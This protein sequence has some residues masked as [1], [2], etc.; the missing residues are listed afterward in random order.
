M[1]VS[2]KLKRIFMLARVMS[3]S[4]ST[5]RVVSSNKLFGQPEGSFGYKVIKAITTAFFILVMVSYS[6]VFGFAYMGAT[7]D[8]RSFSQLVIL[9]LIVIVLLFG[10]YNVGI[11]MFYSQN[12]PSYLTMPITSTELI[13]ARILGF[14]KNTL[15]I[16]L[17]LIPAYFVASLMYGNGILWSLALCVMVLLSVVPI[18]M[19]A[20]LITFFLIRFTPLGNSENIFKGVYGVVSTV[21]SIAMVYVIYSVV[22]SDQGLSS[23]VNVIPEGALEYF[24]AFV[25]PG[26]FLIPQISELATSNLGL[27]L[28]YSLIFLVLCAIYLAIAVLVMRKSYLGIVNTVIAGGKLDDKKAE[29]IKEESSHFNLDD[30]LKDRSQLASFISL[31]FNRFRR[32]PTLFQQFALA[33]I[34]MPIFIMFVFYFSSKKLFNEELGISDYTQM[35]QAL[36]TPEVILFASAMIVCFTFVIAFYVG[37]LGFSYSAFSIEGK[38]FSS[39]KSMPINFSTYFTAKIIT[40][41]I[42]AVPVPLIMFVAG[43]LYIGLSPIHLISFIVSFL[44]GSLGGVSIAMLFDVLMPKLD[45]NNEQELRNRP[46]NFIIMMVLAGVMTFALMALGLILATNELPVYLILA[47]VLGVEAVLALISFVLLITLGKSKLLSIEI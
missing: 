8:I 10:I 27:A 46:L 19:I 6:A 33:P 7:S 4:D 18:A 1:T 40:C 41:L 34:L 12:L 32:N 13:S 11:G 31:D 25:T 22:Y 39:F 3:K 47:I 15:M 21:L 9:A 5:T 14:L 30:E 16:G 42:L 35:G 2:E 23:A 20:L 43:A 28:V 44:L 36:L 37:S 38:S 24:L 17:M 45:A 29:K 26:Y